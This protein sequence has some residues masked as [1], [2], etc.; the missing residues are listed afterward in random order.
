MTVPSL[1]VGSTNLKKMNKEI[2]WNST[3]L[4]IEFWVIPVVVLGT[5]ILQHISV[6]FLELVT[7]T[8][9]LQPSR[10]SFECSLAARET[11]RIRKYRPFIILHDELSTTEA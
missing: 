9:M 2:Q 3:G 11:A 10:L 1:L 8:V 4:T 7:S 6:H 5:L